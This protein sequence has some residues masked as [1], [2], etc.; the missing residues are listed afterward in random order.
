MGKLPAVL[1]ET[2]AGVCLGVIGL[3]V[4]AMM[5]SGEEQMGN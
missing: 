5:F 2:V 3:L 1:R 4:P